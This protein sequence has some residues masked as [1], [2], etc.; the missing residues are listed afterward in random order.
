[1]EAV[2]VDPV[3]K[4]KPAEAHRVVTYLERVVPKGANE[5]AELLA[6]MKRLRGVP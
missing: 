6:L 3:I 1:M 2:E 4:L 5:A